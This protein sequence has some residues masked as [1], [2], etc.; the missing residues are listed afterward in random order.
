MSTVAVYFSCSLRDKFENISRHRDQ[1]QLY[2]TTPSLCT[3][4]Y[5]VYDVRECNNVQVYNNIRITNTQY[6][7][8]SCRFVRLTTGIETI[9]H[10][11][12]ACRLG[13]NITFRLRPLDVRLVISKMSPNIC[14][15]N[16]YF[17][18]I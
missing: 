17:R 16:H 7:V 15:H 3:Y 9:L 2:Y 12:V 5:D 4:L 1:R 13:Q 6:T 18:I 14:C 11:G 8:T 10:S